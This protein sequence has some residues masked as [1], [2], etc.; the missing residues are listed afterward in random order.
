MMTKSK[1]TKIILQWI[2]VTP[3]GTPSIQTRSYNNVEKA[4]IFSDKLNERGIK[5]FNR[6]TVEKIEFV[7]E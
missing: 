7:A 3:D 2:E 4:K 5:V 1:I 6:K